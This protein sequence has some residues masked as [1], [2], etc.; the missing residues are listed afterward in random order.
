[1]PGRGASNGGVR[2]RVR[3]PRGRKLELSPEE[4]AL[5]RR[6]CRYYRGSVPSY[7]ASRREEAAM[8]DQILRRLG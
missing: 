3:R 2:R 6:A 5:L 1:M 8:L 7:L 4:R